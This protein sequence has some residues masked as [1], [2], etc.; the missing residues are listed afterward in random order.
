PLPLFGDVQQDHQL[1]NIQTLRS[2]RH[3]ARKGTL[4]A[5]SWIVPSGANSDHPP[6]SVH[7]SQAYVTAIIN[8]AMKS[9]DWK[10]TAIF[11]SWDDWG[12]FYD[13]V[14]PPAV[15]QNGYGLRGPGLVISPYANVGDIDPQHVTHEPYLK[16]IE[17]DFLSGARLNP[18]TDGRPDNRISVREESPGL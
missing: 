18:A 9:P 11:L 6:A 14:V 1:H 10:S 4:P 15:D 5:V 13:H 17:N 7:R 2:Y 12:G 3:A 8:A 16:F